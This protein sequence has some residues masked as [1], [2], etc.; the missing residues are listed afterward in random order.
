MAP[1]LPTRR[2]D[3]RSRMLRV[4]KELCR[5]RSSANADTIHDLRVAIRRCRS[6]A[7]IME[8]VD[9]HPAWKELR[10]VPRKLFRTLGALRDV[11]VME[12]WVKRLSPAEDPLRVTLLDVLEA[13]QARAR[14]AALG[15]VRTFDEPAWRGLVGTLTERARFVPPNGL[16]AQ[17]LALE[18][19]T[20]L[21]RLH[22]RAVR[23][24]S[25]KAWHAVRIGLKRFRYT[26]ETLLP[27]RAIVWGDGLGHM[28]DALGAIHDLDVLNA[29]MGQVV[30]DRHL[31]S[32]GSLVHAVEAEHHNQIERYLER[33]NGETGLLEEWKAGLPRGGKE[34]AVATAARLRTTARAMDPR[35]Q[36]TAEI[37][38]LAI[39][40]LDAV[41]RSGAD[42]RLRDTGLRVILRAAAQL[43]GIR[44]EGRHC[45]GSG[46]KRARKFLRGTRAPLGW[47]SHDWE[48]VAEIVRYHRGAEP[49]VRSESFARFPIERQERIR[50][51][52]A[53][54]RLAR[55]LHRCGVRVVR[56][57]QVD[58]TAVCLRLRAQGLRYSAADAA[59]LARAKHLLEAHLQRP[60]LV[61]SAGAAAPR[62]VGT[63]RRSPADL[64]AKRGQ[65]AL[66]SPGV[67]LRV[68]TK[69]RRA[70]RTTDS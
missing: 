48:L 1:T 49:D 56:G 7:S 23:T 33:M 14:E 61:E 69:T 43:Q 4:L 34:I 54:L 65:G 31:A 37:A 36:R 55:G 30:S 62:L 50:G 19:Y 70:R 59:R 9:A 28:Q 47:K 32:A 57:I 52:A 24:E 60:I 45:H 35:Y 16:T 67:E 8:E 17:Y 51:L 20:E 41:A 26:V 38:R 3:L 66:G 46:R 27:G 39:G 12:D 15:V 11:Q 10:K 25:P 6:I 13:S 44:V 64:A 21:R 58:D 53:L 5:V 63:N 18:R 2:V 68:I 22:A 29:W 40:L 42:A